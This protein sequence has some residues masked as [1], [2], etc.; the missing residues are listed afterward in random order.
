[1]STILI[2]N[3]DKQESLI[4]SVDTLAGKGD[5]ALVIAAQ[6]G[7]R[8][9]FES[10][11]A[12]HEQ[13]IYFYALRMTRNR[14]DAEDV[15]QQ[16]FQKAFTHLGAFEGK[17]SFSTWLTSVATNEALMLLR[18]SRGSREVPIEDARGN[19]E[20]AFVPEIPDSGPGPEDSYSQRER[21][22]IL[23]AAMNQLTP[24]VRKAIELRELRELSTEETARLMGLSVGAVK[25]RVFHGRK[26]LREILKRIVESTWMSREQTLRAGSTTNGFSRERFAFNAGD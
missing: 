9:A 2:H 20:S 14:Q 18:R 11:V 1:V 16:S 5:M 12:R 8:E 3:I 24:G 7:N 22:R 4:S 21:K 23:F 6:Q 25:A 19:E 10:L 17:S 13:K 26:K 15:A